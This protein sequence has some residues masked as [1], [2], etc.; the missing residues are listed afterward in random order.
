M[1]DSIGP[2]G[3]LYKRSRKKRALGLTYHFHMTRGFSSVVPFEVSRILSCDPIGFLAWADDTFLV[4][5][6][7]EVC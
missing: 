3:V 2:I 6:H 7:G 4:N 1:F 5:V